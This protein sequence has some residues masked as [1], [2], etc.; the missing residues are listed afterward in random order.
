MAAYMAYVRR[1]RDEAPIKEVLVPSPPNQSTVEQL[2]ALQQ[3]LTQLEALIQAGNI[4]LLKT[5]AL[6]LSALPEVSF[7]GSFPL[8]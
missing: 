5:R 6:V 4:F 1:M 2:I 8:V 7:S 3:A